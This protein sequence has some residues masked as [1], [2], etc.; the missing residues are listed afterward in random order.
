MSAVQNNNRRGPPK[1]NANWRKIKTVRLNEREWACTREE[2][3][4]EQELVIAENDAPTVR[5]WGS[6]RKKKEGTAINM[7]KRRI[8]TKKIKDSDK[9]Y[10]RERGNEKVHL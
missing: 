9:Q 8:P 2:V 5:Q 3:K 1:E 4:E 7:K 6:C 10:D